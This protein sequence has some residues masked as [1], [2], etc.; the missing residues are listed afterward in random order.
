MESMPEGVEFSSLP[1]LYS[2]GWR[3][4]ISIASDNEVLAKESFDKYTHLLESK[5]IVYG[6]NDGE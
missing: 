6:L 4:T 3:V 1:K 2:D 5:K